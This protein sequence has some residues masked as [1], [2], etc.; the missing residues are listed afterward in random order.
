MNRTALGV[1][2]LMMLS[3]VLV[4][5]GCSR[6]A[7][8]GSDQL[9]APVSTAGGG[10]GG[11]GAGVPAAGGAGTGATECLPA[12]CRGKVYAC[13][14]CE[15][16]D[17]DGLVDAND[18]ECS[19]PC[20]DDEGSFDVALPGSGSQACEED[21]F[22]DRG[23]GIGNDCRYSQR[24]DPLSVAP[25]YPPSGDASCAYDE[26]AKIPGGNLGCAELG[27]AQPDT[28][29][30][31]CGPLTPNGCDCFGCCELPAGSGSYVALGSRGA[32]GSSCTLATLA[33][34]ASCHPCTPVPSCM[35]PC[36]ACESCVG[37]PAPLPSCGA[38]A[39]A[40]ASLFAPC[41]GARGT[42]C[43]A[44][45]YCITGCCVPEPR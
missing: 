6:D 10:G 43:P 31:V 20:D 7:L 38:A 34:P 30:E 15:D 45:S 41:T 21:C 26:N 44:S 28:C 40:C 14:N 32:D 37:R 13:G 39:P 3:S 4:G 2:R 11:G 29:A 8:L 36:G 5:A 17:G 16:D 24:C 25:D 1:A 18:P 33:D 23:N 42:S 35:N 22:F 9:A 19:G 27:A 12:S